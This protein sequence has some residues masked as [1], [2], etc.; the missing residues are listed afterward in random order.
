MTPDDIRARLRVLEQERDITILF[1]VESGSRAWGLA[2]PDSDYDVRAVFVR[3]EPAYLSVSPPSEDLSALDG[4]F[5]LGA[6]D[7]RKFLRLL[8]KSNATP[9][10]WLQSPIRY[11][12]EEDALHSRIFDFAK[13][14]TLVRRHFHPRAALNHYRGLAKG[15]WAGFSD[16]GEGRLKKFFYV[17]RPLLAARWV[18]ERQTLPPMTFEALLVMLD[19]DLR[20]AVDALAARKREVD[21]A[22]VVTLPEEVRTYVQNTFRELEAADLPRTPQLDATDLDEVFRHAIR[23][24]WSTGSMDTASPTS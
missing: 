8:R 5:D 9:G 10:E 11:R 24:A 14:E 16:S 1:A 4:D 15:A 2:S 7:L 12:G 21:E 19:E 13:F 18:A 3:P 17:L 6:W 23:S 22:C 20:P